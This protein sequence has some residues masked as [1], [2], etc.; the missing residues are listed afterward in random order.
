MEFSSHP[1]QPI[2]Q[3]VVKFKTSKTN[4]ESWFRFDTTALISFKEH[5]SIFYFAFCVVEIR[6]VVQG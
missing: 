4:G 3:S 2:E 5:R 1:T 6:G